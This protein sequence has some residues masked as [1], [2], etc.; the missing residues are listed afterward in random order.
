MSD[1]NTENSSV[2]NTSSNF[3]QNEDGISYSELDNISPNEILD[4]F[5]DDVND[6]QNEENE[7]ENNKIYFTA[8][9]LKQ[10]EKK[11]LETKIPPKKKKINLFNT[12]KDNGEK[13]KKKRGRQTEENNSN[14]DNTNQ[15]IHDK[16]ST[17]N[18]LRKIQVHYMTFIISS[19]N[20]IL[21]DLNYK[22]K[23]L[24]LDYSFKKVINIDYFESLKKKSLIEIICNNISKKYKDKGENI[25]YEIYEKIKE[26]E[27][28]KNFFN[29]NYITF[30]KEVYYKSDK[31]INFEKYGLD[32]AITLSNDVKMFKDLLA[33]NRDDAGNNKEYIENINLCVSQNYI[34]EN[35][36]LTN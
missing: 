15:T 30:F 17:D 13:L 10:I 28:L 4:V 34:P 21:K 9:F 32:R 3:H 24:K 14:K 20:A 26:N 5:V 29:E 11:K 25:N 2:L 12:S 22:E 23:F 18:I 16:F 19:S 7:S 33:N 27:V 1:Y 6:S 8:E 35:K 31:I 36:F